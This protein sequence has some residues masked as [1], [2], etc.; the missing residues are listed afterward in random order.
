MVAVN[1]VGED[2]EGV[3]VTVS[4]YNVV[5]PKRPSSDRLLKMYPVGTQ[6]LIKDPYLKVSNS[7]M[8]AI[9]LDHP[10]NLIVLSADGEVPRPPPEQEAERLKAEGNQCF[11]EGAWADAVGLYDKALVL[12]PP[13]ELSVV[14]RSNKAQVSGSLG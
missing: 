13:A 8:L 1:T 9:R 4:L 14:L 12:K 11:A 5:G 6:L 3:C 7:G 10:A 2:G